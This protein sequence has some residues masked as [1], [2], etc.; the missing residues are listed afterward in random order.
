VHAARDQPVHVAAQFRLVYFALVIQGDNVRCEDAV[1]GALAV[2]LS[3][4][5]WGV[6]TIASIVSGVQTHSIIA[7]ASPSTNSR[8]TVLLRLRAREMK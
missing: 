5:R 6:V 3:E 7:Q 8:F 1:Q 4:N 2:I